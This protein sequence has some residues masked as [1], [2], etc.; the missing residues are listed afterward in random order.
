MSLR[1]RLSLWVIGVS[2]A[3]Q[4]LVLVVSLQEVRQAAVEGARSEMVRV[5]RRR[6]E[7]MGRL[8]ELGRN[9]AEL[10]PDELSKLLAPYEFLLEQ[11]GRILRS[12]EAHAEDVSAVQE[13]L[14]Q[15]RVEPGLGLE[16]ERAGS[17]VT[18]GRSPRWLVSQPIPGG[19]RTLVHVESEREA[20]KQQDLFREEILYVEALGTALLVLLVWLVAD[21]ITRPLMA[22]RVAVNEMARGNLEAPIPK[23]PRRD[24]VHDLAESFV[25]MQVSLRDLAKGS[26]IQRAFLPRAQE[27]DL[28]RMGGRLDVATEFLPARKVSGDLYDLFPLGPDR[29]AVVIGDVSGK[30]VSAAMLTVVTHTLLRAEAQRATGPAACLDR[31]NRLMCAEDREDRAGIFVT[32]QYLVVDLREGTLTYAN[33]GHLPPVLLRPGSPPRPLDLP[34]GIVLGVDPDA[35]FEEQQVRLEPGDTLLL[36]TD[37]LSEAADPAQALFGE[38]R[39]AE[40]A[41]AVAG[42]P[43]PDLLDGIL[44]SMRDFTRGHPQTDDLTLL[45]LRRLS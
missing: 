10:P 19:T 38:E 7:E 30:G 40:V 44:G 31:V 26:E 41:G 25:Q 24:E 28:A 17:V 36:Y 32:L 1:L 43:L 21:E 4:A 8:R 12:R 20:L 16:P 29:L 37:G 13:A 39:V 11:D 9:L 35:T 34:G 2:V 22:L 42:R 14:D 6:A 27:C 18:G 33:A 15:G 5:V 45:A 23:V 3:I